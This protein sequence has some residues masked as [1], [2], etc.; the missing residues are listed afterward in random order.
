MSQTEGYLFYGDSNTNLQIISDTFVN[1]QLSVAGEVFRGEYYGEGNV[2]LNVNVLVG[3]L[4]VKIDTH[5]F[6]EFSNGSH[7]DKN[8]TESKTTYTS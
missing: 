3:E 1:D 4:N 6:K 8:F 2:T 5:E 7:F